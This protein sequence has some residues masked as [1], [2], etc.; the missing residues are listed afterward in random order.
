MYWNINEIL[1]YQRNFNLIDSERT[2]GK[3]YTTEKF[4]IKKCM[5]NSLQF[6]YIVRTKTER[7][8]ESY[9]KV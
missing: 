8:R 6:V 9:K 4:L 2:I 7:I 5:E 3:T 1:P